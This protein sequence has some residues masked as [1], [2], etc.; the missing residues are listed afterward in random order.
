LPFHS[1]ASPSH[2]INTLQGLF[3]CSIQENHRNC[4]TDFP[5]EIPFNLITSTRNIP[6]RCDS[7]S[8]KSSSS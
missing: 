7:Y 2:L 1:F 3:R 8:L 6:A 5:L 4:I